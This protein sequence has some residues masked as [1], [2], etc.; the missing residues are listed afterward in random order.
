[1]KK[2]EVLAQFLQVLADEECANG[3]GAIMDS[4]V[5][6]IEYMPT[7][8]KGDII[9]SVATKVFDIYYRHRVEDD[10]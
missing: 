7:L 10:K 4:L 6:L 5:R 2:R 3:S 8:P 9:E 1:M